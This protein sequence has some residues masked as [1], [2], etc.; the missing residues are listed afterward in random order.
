MK[1]IFIYSDMA[2]HEASHGYLLNTNPVSDLSCYGILG[3]KM[4]LY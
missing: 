1:E 4:D 2:F 3:I